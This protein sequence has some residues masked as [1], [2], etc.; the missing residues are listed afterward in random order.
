[1]RGLVQELVTIAPQM[2]FIPDSRGNYPLHLAI[3]NQHTYDIIYQLYR[4]FPAVGKIRD[5]Q[6]KLVPFMLAAMGSWKSERDQISITYQLLR[7][8]PLL[9]FGV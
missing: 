9:V 6:T 7:E 8:D 1:M 3:G 5:A 4:T 2:A